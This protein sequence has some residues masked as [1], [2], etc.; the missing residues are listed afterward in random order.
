MNVSRA[1]LENILKVIEEGV[2]EGRLSR[3][4]A[5]LL[6]SLVI[7]EFGKEIKA[8]SPISNDNTKPFAFSDEQEIPT[9]N[10][11]GMRSLSALPPL[12]KK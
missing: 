4:E 11:E 3:Q 10:N 8:G 9:L 5:T 6:E 12:K 7:I 1:S 2:S